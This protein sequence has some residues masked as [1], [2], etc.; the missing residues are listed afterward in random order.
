MDTS[1]L[2][3]E[4]LGKK[5]KNYNE[6]LHKAL[7]DETI[8]KIEDVDFDK[9]DQDNLLIIDVACEKKNVEFVLNILKSEDMMYVS[10]ALQ[11]STWL[12]TD[13]QYAHIINPQYVREQLLPEMS[14]KAGLKLLKYIRRY[15][16]NEPR[17]EQFY[18]SENRIKEALKWLPNCSIPFIKKHVKLHADKLE[19]KLFKRLCEKSIKVFEIVIG[20]TYYS[21]PCFDIAKFLLKTNTDQFLDFLEDTKYSTS[22]PKFNVKCTELLMKESR[23]R[24]L[25]KFDKYVNLI[26]IATFAKHIE[27]E[28]IK[29]FLLE[30]AN[31]AE[32]DRINYDLRNF[33]KSHEISYLIKRIPREERFDFVKTVFIDNIAQQKDNVI[34][35]FDSEMYR[36]K[37]LSQACGLKKHEWYQFAPFHIAFEAITKMMKMEPIPVKKYPM[38]I[39]LICI[40]GK[41]EENLQTLL[42]YYISNHINDEY[43][44]KNQFISNLIK[45]SP[46][47]KYSKIS[48]EILNEIFKSMNVY[49]DK[50]QDVQDCVISI[51]LH[52][53]LNNE[54]VPEIIIKKFSFETLKF[55][56]NKLNNEEQEKVFTFLYNY[57]VRKIQKQNVTTETELKEI[58]KTLEQ[59]LNLLNDWKKELVAYPFVLNKI[60]EITKIKHENSWKASLSALYNINKSWRKHMF[61]ES[62]LLY[63]SQDVCVN[64]LKHD[65]GLLLRYNQEVKQICYDDNVSMKLLHSKLR[66]Y[67]PESLALDWANGYRERLKNLE[68]HKA[69]V[70]GL[71][72][73][74]PE[75]SLIDIIKNY[76]PE[77]AKINWKE[78]DEVTISLRRHIAKNMHL[79]RPQL[80]PNAIF[81]YAKGDYLQYAL[82]SLLAVFYN[83][84]SDLSREFIPKLLDAPVS[85]QKHGIR[86]AFLRLEP[87]KLK[88]IFLN[89]WND[90]NNPSIRAELFKHTFKLLKSEETDKVE[91]VWTLLQLFINNLNH[92]DDAKLFDLL[93]R[94]DEVPSLIRPNYIVTCYNAYKRLREHFITDGVY[95]YERN[96]DTLIEYCKYIIESIDKEFISQIIKDYLNK[97]LFNFEGESAIAIGDYNEMIKV[98]SGYLLYATSIE[99]QTELYETILDPVLTRLFENKTN[100]TKQSNNLQN[101]STLLFRIYID[102]KEYVLDKHLIIPYKM[103][104]SI[105]QKLE[106]LPV[107]EN[108]KMLTM[109]KLATAL[110]KLLSEYDT[111]CDWDDI[112]L[113]IAPEFANFCRSYLKEEVTTR[114]SCIYVL[115]SNVLHKMLNAIM[116]TDTICKIYECM[117]KDKDFVQAFL[118]VTSIIPAKCYL[119]CSNEVKYN[120]IHTIIA[121]RPVPEIK[122]HYY[123]R[124]PTYAEE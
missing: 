71:C 21:L 68:G 43:N 33:L 70:R 18:L 60:K 81:W 102:L 95:R 2:E 72:G 108:Y 74:I 114:F 123:S 66:I 115:F 92:T 75:K 41:S 100:L 19:P 30:Q 4:N 59:M 34:I 120:K 55:Y 117:L 6:F 94:M 36:M 90:S 17:V 29:D 80:N 45:K 65:P 109:W 47:Y 39:T 88:T 98:V 58:S 46:V 11:K 42:K 32:S 48:W 14:T 37:K 24:I 112:T 23:D 56:R 35:P 13:D 96:M 82:P 107:P 31:K 61:E 57:L 89:I 16:N 83:M 64:A 7:K 52:N 110:A 67:W 101:L 93:V 103:F 87:T 25:E 106:S 44:L 50:E 99:Q 22:L 73:L 113:D 78:I 28:S 63:P 79:A 116:S 15:L 3:H 12:F 86:F 1:T 8:I 105:Q 62:L 10:R 111:T 27:K 54:E 40:V 84:N 104:C 91:E 26:D 53:C 118:S 49:I 38:L 119:T 97:K 20:N 9:N 69:V 77:E 124:F 51:V 121:E 85:V 76:A 5:H 122:M